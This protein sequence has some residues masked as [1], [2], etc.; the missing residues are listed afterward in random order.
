MSTSG[1][2]SCFISYEAADACYDGYVK[3]H[4]NNLEKILWR[5]LRAQ[6]FLNFNTVYWLYLY[7]VLR[8]DFFNVYFFLLFIAIMTLLSFSI[9]G[10]YLVIKP[11][12]DKGKEHE[13]TAIEELRMKNLAADM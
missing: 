4:S 8:K 2:F 10:I 5:A 13:A 6:V 12:K 11:P 3:R 9:V 1:L 7:Y